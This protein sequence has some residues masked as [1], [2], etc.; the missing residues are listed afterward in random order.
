MPQ[1]S[2]SNGIPPSEVTQSTTVKIPFSLAS[3]TKFFSDFAPVE[4]SACTKV[5]SFASGF[6]VKAFSTFSKLTGLHHHPL[7]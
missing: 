2:I 5:K 6:S 4:V 3:A 7:K 1:L